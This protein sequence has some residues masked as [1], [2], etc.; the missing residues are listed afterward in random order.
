MFGTILKEGFIRW[1]DKMGYAILTSVWGAL[2]PFTIYFFLFVLLLVF[3]QD[4]SVIVANLPN[5]LIVFPTMFLVSGFF[6]TSFAAVAIQKRIGDLDTIYFRNYFPD[7]LGALVKSLLPFLKLTAI[8]GIF[9]VLLTVSVVFYW[10]IIPIFFFKVVLAVLLIWVYIIAVLSS[11]VIVP[12]LIYNDS[13]TIRDAITTSFKILFTEGV[14]ILGIFIIDMLVF[15][16]CA[17]SVVMLP[18]LYYGISSSLRIY[19]HKEIIAKYSPKPKEEEPAD[20][21]EVDRQAW[22]T[23]LKK[24]RGEE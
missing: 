12:L 7:L 19:T 8:Y 14:A 21:D 17:I 24:A 16:I 15:A 20:P 18:V 22:R 9:G 3:S 4:K 1:W 2:N 5:Y 6:P 23:L 11:Y 10:T 13:L